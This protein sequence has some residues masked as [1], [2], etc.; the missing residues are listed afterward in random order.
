LKVELVGPSN[1]GTVFRTEPDSASTTYYSRG[2]NWQL[3]H[4]AT[5]FNAIGARLRR[6]GALV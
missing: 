1:T 3:S 2:R 6:D 4:S 5:N